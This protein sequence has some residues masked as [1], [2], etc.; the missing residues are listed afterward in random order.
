MRPIYTLPGIGSLREITIW[1]AIVFGILTFGI[2]VLVVGYQNSQDIQRARETPFDLWV[3]FF[4][5]GIFFWPLMVVLWVFN[6]IGVSEIRSR[7]GL[8]DSP[9]GIVSLIFA[10][11]FPPIGQLLWAFHVNETLRL[12]PRS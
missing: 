2:Y 4:I 10:V 6:L 12:G 3:V 1:K 7:M 11:V 5:L 8:S 9:M